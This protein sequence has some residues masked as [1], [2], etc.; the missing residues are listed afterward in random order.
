MVEACWVVVRQLDAKGRKREQRAGIRIFPQRAAYEVESK[1][2]DCA[3][4]VAS[5]SVAQRAQVGVQTIM[6]GE[7]DF[8][9]GTKLRD[10]SAIL[11]LRDASQV[12]AHG[13]YYATLLYR[14]LPAGVSE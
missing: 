9:C 2:W 3:E 1:V 10:G 4:R 12:W 6:Q 8:L 11:A 5:V 7:N 14:S 13:P